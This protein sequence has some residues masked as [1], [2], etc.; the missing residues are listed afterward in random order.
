MREIIKNLNFSDE[1]LTESLNFKS[2]K[3][4]QKSSAYLLSPE[5]SA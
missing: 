1:L 3:L 4:Q 5:S 2:Q